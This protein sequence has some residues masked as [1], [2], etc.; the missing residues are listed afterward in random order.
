MM[1]TI[2]KA[3]RSM[4]SLLV[5]LLLRMGRRL[6]IQELEMFLMIRKVNLEQQQ[7]LVAR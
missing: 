5:Q 2:T 1:T 6:L 7:Q 3:N 4:V